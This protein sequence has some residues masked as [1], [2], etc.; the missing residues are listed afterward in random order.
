[1]AVVKSFSEFDLLDLET[2]KEILNRFLYRDFVDD[3]MARHVTVEDP[4]FDPSLAYL[5]LDGGDIV[6]ILIGAVRRVAPVELLDKH[7]GIAWIKVIAVD[8]R[9]PDRDRV[10][11][12]L[13]YRFLDDAKSMGVEEVRYGNFV[14]WYLFPGID[15][16]YEYTLHKLLENGFERYDQC[17]DYEV[18]LQM[19]WIPRRVV[20][21]EERLKREGIV[22][23][24]GVRGE[25]HRVASWVLQRFGAAWK[26]EVLFAYTKRR[27]PTILIAERDGEILGF[28]CY[29]ALHTTWFGPIGVAEEARGLGIGTVLL[30]RA[31][32]AM[33]LNGIRIA[34][35]PWTNHLFFYTQL[36][37]IVNVRHFWMVRRKL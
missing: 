18:D 37:N 17:V 2:V 35:I 3:E 4:N 19:F 13:L 5:A 30:Y 34:R 21:R 36:E 15:L 32:E 33:R 14:S 8:E 27:K 12:A 7:R 20:E 1:M 28:A 25:E 23:R 6:G 10:F 16:G 9:R 11:D 31:L 22:V 26:Q 29:S 24:K